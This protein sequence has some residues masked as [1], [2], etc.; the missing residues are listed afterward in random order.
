MSSS[1]LSIKM[2]IAY[3][4]AVYCDK[5]F[6]KWFFRFEEF[7]N[8]REK[9]QMKRIDPMYLIFTVIVIYLIC[10]IFFYL[11]HPELCGTYDRSNC[12]KQN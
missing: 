1:L 10:T 9:R 2:E 12:M 6:K 8:R 11:F 3:R 7:F 4:M 5:R